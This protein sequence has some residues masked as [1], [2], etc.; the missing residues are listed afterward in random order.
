MIKK[1]KLQELYDYVKPR[2]HEFRY[3]RFFESMPEYEYYHSGKIPPCGTTACLAGH[4]V[5]LWGLTLPRYND[6]FYTV[7]TT[8]KEFLGLTDDESY[9]LFRQNSD[10]ATHE[11]ALKRLQ[12]LIDG[13][14]V[15]DYDWSQE[16]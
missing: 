12:W 11:D 4:A 3:D 7:D 10:C 16:P 8:V 9:F 1:A 2:E 13:H 6:I 14:Q 15:V 5:I